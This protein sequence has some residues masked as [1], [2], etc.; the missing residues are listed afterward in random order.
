MEPVFY[1]EFFLEDKMKD[2]GR[3]KSEHISIGNWL[4]TNILLAIPGVNLIAGLCYLFSKKKSK[5]NYVL[6]LIILWLIVAALI[7]IA[8]GVLLIFFKDTW[9]T[10]WDQAKTLLDTIPFL[11]DLIG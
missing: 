7:G 5:R 1:I 3:Q 4:L 8:V 10:L 11:S 9:A 6:A 2:Y